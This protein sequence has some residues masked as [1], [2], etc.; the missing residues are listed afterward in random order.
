MDVLYLEFAI[1]YER[2]ISSYKY[3][4]SLPVSYQNDVL[5]NMMHFDFILLD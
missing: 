2:I 3:H 5:G 4:T 1:K